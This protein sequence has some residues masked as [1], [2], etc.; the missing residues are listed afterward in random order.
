MTE[1]R[2]AVDRSSRV[3][4]Y[5]LRLGILLAVWWI[6]SGSH[7]DWWFGLPLAMVAAALSLWLAPPARFLLRPH[8]IPQFAG[9][10]LWQSLLAGWDVARRTLSPSLPLQPEILRLPMALP[11]G[12]PTWWLMLTIT[13]LPGTLSVRLSRQ[14]VLEVHCLDAR[15]DVAGS[16]RETEAHLARLFGVQLL[17]TEDGRRQ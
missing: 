10:F 17:P 12:A 14:R 8:Q 11:P 16:V 1:Q 4:V 13:L 3:S 2:H 7:S 15:L 6:V 9:F 5:V